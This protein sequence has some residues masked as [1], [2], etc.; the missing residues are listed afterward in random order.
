MVGFCDWDYCRTK[1]PRGMKRCPD[2]RDM[3]WWQEYTEHAEHLCWEEEALTLDE[4]EETLDIIHDAR[5]SGGPRGAALQLESQYGIDPSI[6]GERF[7]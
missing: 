4:F 1:I 2:H 5:G 6:F 3:S 7:K